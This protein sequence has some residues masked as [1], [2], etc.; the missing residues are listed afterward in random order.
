MQQGYTTQASF[1]STVYI[2]EWGSSTAG[3]PKKYM[4]FWT[5]IP[6]PNASYN[7]ASR[8]HL[9]LRTLATTTSAIDLPSGA[10]AAAAATAVS[11][12]SSSAT[13]TPTGGTIV[14]QVNAEKMEK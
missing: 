6:R 2:K 4:N 10:A 5:A 12:T 8:H 13:S 3:L 7:P 9:N 14:R 1:D 11:A